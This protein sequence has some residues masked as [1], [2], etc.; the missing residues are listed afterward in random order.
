MKVNNV[1]SNTT[2]ECRVKLVKSIAIWINMIHRSDKWT[3]TIG[4]LIYKCGDHKNSQKR[5][6]ATIEGPSVYVLAML[7]EYTK[8]LNCK[9][10]DSIGK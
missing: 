3:E 7:D 5:T 2:C 4:M 6:L 1:K 10:N 9:Y 8:H